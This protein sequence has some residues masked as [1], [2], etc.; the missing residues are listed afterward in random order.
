MRRHQRRSYNRHP[1]RQ[2]APRP[3]RLCGQHPHGDA[4]RD[5][6]ERGGH[7]PRRCSVSAWPQPDAGIGPPQP[8]TAPPSAETDEAIDWA[9]VTASAEESANRRPARRKNSSPAAI[10]VAILLG[11]AIV[12]GTAWYVV[13]KMPAGPQ[14]VVIQLPAAARPAKQSRP[15]DLH[16]GDQVSSDAASPSAGAAQRRRRQCRPA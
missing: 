12:G 4:Y 3:R 11:L 2:F 6:C 14:V 15:R 7:A 10:V 13:K 9:A 8:R 5:L 16:T 1:P